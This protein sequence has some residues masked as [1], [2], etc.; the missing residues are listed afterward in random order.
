[1]ALACA[2]L[3]VPRAFCQQQDQ[4]VGRAFV[5]S[6]F[7]YLDSPHIGL[8][9]PGFH[10]QAGIRYSRHISLGFDYSR[11]T[12]NTTL[13]LDLATT[14]LQGEINPLLNQ[15]KAGGAVPAGYVPA[16][17]LSSVTHTF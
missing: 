2:L 13:G 10:I 12:G 7:I 1:M 9:E 6:G 11:G 15:L 8:L 17:P 4:Y 5:Y 14:A 16:L 3:A